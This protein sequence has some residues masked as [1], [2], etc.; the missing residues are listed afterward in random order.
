MAVSDKQRRETQEPTHLVPA[1]PP[2]PGPRAEAETGVSEGTSGSSTGAG[3]R[4]GALMDKGELQQLISGRPL[5]RLYKDPLEELPA[6]VRHV[7]GKHG[8]GGLSGNL[9]DGR[10]G[11]ELGP[12]R[13]LGQHFH[14]S[15]AN[16]P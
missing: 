4:G 5:L 15:A 9:K 12:G 14:H 11:F 8:V 10:H 6:V 16:T 13:S 2:P 3:G 7:S 1:T